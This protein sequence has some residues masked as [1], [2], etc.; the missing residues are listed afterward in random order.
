MALNATWSFLGT[1]CIFFGIPWTFWYLLTCPRGKLMTTCH[2]Q[3][4]SCLTAP[5]G[6]IIYCL[7]IRGQWIHAIKRGATR[8]KQWIPPSEFSYICRRH[9]TDEDYVFLT[10][11][12]NYKTSHQYLYIGITRKQ[13]SQSLTWILSSITRIWYATISNFLWSIYTNMY[14][15]YHLIDDAL[16]H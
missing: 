12:G 11:Y 4:A 2:R 10:T 9:F 14:V 15:Q 8:F 6:G 13:F 3:H 16:L 7:K 1:N 5:G